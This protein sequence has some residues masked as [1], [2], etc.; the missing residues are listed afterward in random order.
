MLRS[1]SPHSTCWMTR[2]E[3]WRGLLMRYGPTGSLGLGSRR[4]EAYSPEIRCGTA[5]IELGFMPGPQGA[6][7]RGW[8]ST[9]SRFWWRVS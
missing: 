4:S 2:I 1:A 8:N 5:R 3:S 9:D 6:C 7:Y